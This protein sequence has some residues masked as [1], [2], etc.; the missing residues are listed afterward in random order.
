MK[1]LYFKSYAL[2]SIQNEMISMSVDEIRFLMCLRNPFIIRY[3]ESFY[4]GVL[5][6]IL[7][8][9]CQV[10]RV[11]FFN[12]LIQKIIQY[13]KGGDLEQ[14]IKENSNNNLKFSNELIFSW[15]SDLLR[16]AHYLHENKVIHRDIKPA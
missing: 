4:E 8:E 16:G 14:K 11:L 15:I 3:F 10:S 13:Q 7:I 12:N 1:S 2:K 9:Y 6:C 5:F